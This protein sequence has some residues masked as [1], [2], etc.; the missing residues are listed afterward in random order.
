METIFL[1]T[2]AQ[3]SGLLAEHTLKNGKIFK[4]GI[5]YANVGVTPLLWAACAKIC[6]TFAKSQRRQLYH[7]QYDPPT[8]SQFIPNS[9][10]SQLFSKL[11]HETLLCCFFPRFFFCISS[12]PLLTT[13]KSSFSTFISVK[14]V[15]SNHFFFFFCKIKTIETICEKFSHFKNSHP[16][17]C[18]FWP[19]LRN[20]SNIFAR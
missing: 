11:K 2:A 1:W 10:C 6:Q 3:N 8:F 7:F 13:F 20:A 5:S 15:S 17:L 4:K 9:I 14:I 12:P 19:Q 18:G 16:Q